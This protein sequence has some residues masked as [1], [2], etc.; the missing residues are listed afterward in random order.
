MKKYIKILFATLAL[1][2][3]LMAVSDE[4]QWL[5]GVFVNQDKNALAKTLTFCP[6]GQAL[7]DFI[8]AAYII[9]GRDDDRII[10]LYSNGAFRLKVSDK[11]NELLPENDFTKEWLTKSSLKHDPNQQYEC[12]PRF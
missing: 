11:G 5:E 10:T 1:G 12:K 3:P 8:R 6:A 2:M 7:F 9:E 4:P